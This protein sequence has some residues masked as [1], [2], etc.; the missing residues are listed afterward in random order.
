MVGNLTKPYTHRSTVPYPKS[1]LDGSQN[2]DF[3]GGYGVL[4]GMKVVL[5]HLRE[6]PIPY[7]AHLYFCRE[8]FTLYININIHTKLNQKRQNTPMKSGRFLP[9]NKLWKNFEFLTALDFEITNKRS[10]T[11]ILYS[12]ALFLLILLWSKK[13][14]ITNGNDDTW[15]VFLASNHIISSLILR[16]EP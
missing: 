11:F 4:E 9:S 6:H 16:L 7:E 2:S 8:I 12:I 15:S 10:C 3:F 5:Q 14:S 13:R 1:L